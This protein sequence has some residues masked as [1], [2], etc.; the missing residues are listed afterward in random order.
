[1]SINKLTLVLVLSTLAITA[2]GLQEKGKSNDLLDD[3]TTCGVDDD[4]GVVP[5]EDAAVPEEDAAVPEEDAATPTP[6]DDAGTVVVPPVT[7]CDSPV[8]KTCGPNCIAAHKRYIS[9]SATATFNFFDGSATHCFKVDPADADGYI[10]CHLTGGK[11]GEQLRFNYL[12][13]NNAYA[14]FGDLGS[15]LPS[16][17]DASSVYCNWYDAAKGTTFTNGPGKDRCD[18]YAL[19]GADGTIKFDGN[20]GSLDADLSTK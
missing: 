16:M 14:Q 11:T 19:L 5:T 12:D 8:F 6:T 1:M 10:N 15:D 2:C 17:C 3:C 7:A 13:T 18:G 4:A 20:A 9:G